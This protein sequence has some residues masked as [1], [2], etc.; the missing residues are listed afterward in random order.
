[1]STV[2]V[3]H[4][5]PSPRLRRILEALVTG[6]DH[7]ELEGIAVESV[8]ALA[9]T[10]DHVLRADG[11]VLLT[12]A[13]FGYM[14]GALKH[15]FDRNYYTCEGAVAGR[16]Y[17]LCVHGDNDT[18][19]AVTSVERIATGW[20]LQAVAPAVRLTGEPGRQD[21]DTAAEVAATV[22]AHLLG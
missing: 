14:S 11:Y 18:A 8:P 1:M 16:P 21:L 20:G 12:P 13:N 4:H 17:A 6:L 22:A 10:D 19:G 7:P 9:T 5:A 15:F 3:V 2:L